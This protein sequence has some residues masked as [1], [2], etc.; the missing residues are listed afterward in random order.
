MKNCQLY[1]KFY[2]L[3]LQNLPLIMYYSSNQL[4]S[5]HCGSGSST[6]CNA[7]SNFPSF[8][9]WT[10]GG[11]FTFFYENTRAC[12]LISRFQAKAFDQSPWGLQFYIHMIGSDQ[13]T[14]SRSPSIRIQSR[15]LFSSE[16]STGYLEDSEELPKSATAWIEQ[17]EDRIAKASDLRICKTNG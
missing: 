5:F 6:K 3:S 7:F 4:L 8:R 2:L 13:K 1:I 12:I 11:N 14:R 16:P 17:S 9:H 10:K 15:D